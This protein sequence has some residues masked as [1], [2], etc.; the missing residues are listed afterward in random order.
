MTADR[1]L[2]NYAEITAQKSI[3]NQVYA[4]RMPA[5]DAGQLSATERTHLL[6]WLECGSP[7]N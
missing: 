4:C 5:Y 1:P 7:Q 6:E 2:T 3:L